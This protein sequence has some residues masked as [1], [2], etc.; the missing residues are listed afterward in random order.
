MDAFFVK[1]PE[2]VLALGYILL[3]V[4]LVFS[5]LERRVRRTAKPLP[6]P[7]R[8]LVNNPTGME[9]LSNIVAT[10]ILLDDGTRQLY[11]PARLRQTFDAVMQG[12]Q[13]EVSAYTHPPCRASA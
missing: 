4:C 9:I 10:V 11:V 2:R 13:V 5:V 7:A 8:G 12:T 3:L 6:T 1:K